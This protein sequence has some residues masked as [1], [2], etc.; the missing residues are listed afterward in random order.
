MPG[1]DGAG[2]SGKGPMTGTCGAGEQSGGRG[3]GRGWGMG[4]GKSDTGRGRGHG[5]GMR[6]KGGR[7]DFRPSER[8]RPESGGGQLEAMVAALEARA[9]ELRRQAGLGPSPVSPEDLSK[10][11]GRDG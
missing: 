4:R 8:L 2:P 3:W 11:D 6:N 9:M 1:N 7:P 5:R 10:D